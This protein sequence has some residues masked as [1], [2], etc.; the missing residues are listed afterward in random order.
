MKIEWEHVGKLL[1]ALAGS[2]IVLI[3]IWWVL[4]NVLRPK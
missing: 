2:A 4:I 1:L 3:G